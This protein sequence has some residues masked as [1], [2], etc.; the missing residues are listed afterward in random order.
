V[1]TRGCIALLA[2]DATEAYAMFA[3]AKCRFES[4]GEAIHAALSSMYSV[5]AAVAL[6]RFEEAATAANDAMRFF[7]AALCPLA[8]LEAA[9]R[10]RAVLGRAGSAGQVATTVQEIAATVRDL[11]VRHGGGLILMSPSQ[12]H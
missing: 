6:G 3:D 2:G 8:T 1:F 4:L 9:A 7:E 5:E 12:S 10:L 11:A